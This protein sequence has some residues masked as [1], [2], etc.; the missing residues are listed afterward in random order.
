[1]TTRGINKL[2]ALQ[3]KKTKPDP[4]KMYKL[5][6]GGNLYLRIDQSGSKYWIFNYTRPFLGKRNDL[7]L[8]TYPEV[9][10]DDA[11]TIRDEYKKL[12]KQGIDPAMERIE[13]K[14]QKQKEAENTFRIV[15]EA[16][17]Y[18]R[19]LEQKQ[20]E[21]TVRRLKHDVYPYVGDLTFP[22]LT[23]EILEVKVFKRIIERGA[24]SVPNGLNQTST[25]SL[26]QRV[27][28]S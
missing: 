3:V 6:D 18:K 4:D 28:K 26:N 11:R 22:Q 20:D 16:W 13:T 7:S 21:E 27:K 25:R 14:S 24:L 1:M 23:L 17:L 2:S 19:E 5:S 8:G 9:S 12:I 10:L 15:A